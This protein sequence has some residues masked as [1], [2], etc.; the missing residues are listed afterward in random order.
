MLMSD[1]SIIVRGGQVFSTRKLSE[2]DLN[3][4]EQA[5]LMY[6]LGHDES[7]QESIAKFYMLD[8]GSIA[9]TLAKLESKGFIDRKINNDNQRE[10][11]ITLTEKSRNIRCVLT[12]LLVDWNDLMYEGIS[13]D[14]IKQFELITSKIAANISSKL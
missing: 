14:E 13:E 5:V 12:D 8:K 2:Y 9:R 10:K 1:L 7:N 3:A 6:L 11:I 4:G